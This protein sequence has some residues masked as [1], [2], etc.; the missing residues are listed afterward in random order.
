MNIVLPP[1][2]S[3]SQDE[4]NRRVVEALQAILLELAAIRARLDA[5]EAS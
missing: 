4:Q 2:K 5:L 3:P 1:L